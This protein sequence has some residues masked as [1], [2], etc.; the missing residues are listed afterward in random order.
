MKK[1]FFFVAFLLLFG[2]SF[3]QVAD[4]TD[5]IPGTNVPEWISYI[6]NALLLLISGWLTKAKLRLNK[7]VPL[8][9]VL[10]RVAER[11]S[12]ST[13]EINQAIDDAKALVAKEK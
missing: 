2:V 10:I 12:T 4:S 1:L 9:E 8:L 13:A 3:A 5:V 11:G 7:A 6:V